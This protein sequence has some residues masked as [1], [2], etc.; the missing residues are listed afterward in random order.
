MLRVFLSVLWIFGIGLLLMLAFLTDLTPAQFVYLGVGVSALVIST[1]AR[2]A[3][4]YQ[5]RTPPP[6]KTLGTDD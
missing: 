6:E 2:T 5:T 4:H 1:W 3:L